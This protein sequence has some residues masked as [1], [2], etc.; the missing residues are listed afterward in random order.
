MGA[1]QLSGDGEKETAEETKV[2]SSACGGSGGCGGVTGDAGAGAAGPAATAG[3]GRAGPPNPW[4]K[5]LSAKLLE[6]DSGE[7]GGS[8]DSSRTVFQ[9][10]LQAK[11]TEPRGLDSGI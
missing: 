2:S 11:E 8:L 7:F 5:L 10:H 6:R 9:K 3:R 4:R 1:E